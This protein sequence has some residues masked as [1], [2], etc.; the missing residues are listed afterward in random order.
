M[1][2]QDMSKGSSHRAWR[3]LIGLARPHRLRIATLLLLATAQAILVVASPW[4]V[5]QAVDMGIPAAL[6]RNFWPLAGIGATL[7]LCA[8][9]AGLLS[10]LWYKRAGEIGQLVV[11]DLRQNLF[12]KYQRLP[13]SF[14][15][16]TA[17]GQ[18]IARLTSDIETVNSLFGTTLATMLQSVIGILL[19]LATMVWLDWVLALLVIG[20]LAPLGFITVWTVSQLQAAFSRSHAAVMQITVQIVESLNGIR[21]V[22]MFRREPVNDDSFARQVEAARV[23]GRQIELV[24]SVYYPISEMILSLAVLLVLLVGSLK[25]SHGQLDVGILTAFVLYV[26]QLSSPIIGMMLVLDAFQ[27]A[28]IALA[29]IADGLREAESVGEQQV[30]VALSND[31]RGEIRFEGVRF[32]YRSTTNANPVDLQGGPPQLDFCLASGSIVAIVGETGAGKSTIAKLITRFYDPIEGRILL[33]GVDLRSI[34]E[35][36][37]RRAVVMLTQEGFLFAGS[38]ADNIRIARP[39]ASQNEIEA[40]A[41]SVG[42][43]FFIAKLPRGYLTDVQKRGARFSAGQRQLIA[44]ARAALA[45]PRVLILDEATSALDIPTERS[46]QLALRSLLKGRTAIVIAHRFSTVTM[47][48]QVIVVAD[49]KIVDHGPT[50]VILS[51]GVPQLAALYQDGQGR[52]AGAK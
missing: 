33:D 50:E 48:D 26:A 30:L 27:S 6:D 18:M 21:P 46:M 32:D 52:S 7:C 41:R 44:F 20:C 43:H 15:D 45:D 19:T 16:R 3:L 2:E 14:Y 49:G 22:Q 47:A 17:S 37:L 38:V 5:S 10:L 40:A 28:M 35:D 11:F 13:I 4:L 25:A 23:S 31:L 29:K 36:D 24:R 51:K 1:P 34:A 42:A 39:S 9:G 8:A 12:R